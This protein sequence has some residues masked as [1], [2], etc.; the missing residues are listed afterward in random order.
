MTEFDPGLTNSMQDFSICSKL[1]FSV[2]LK[3][4][5]VLKAVENI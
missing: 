4:S 5:Y 2:L 3:Y 1:A